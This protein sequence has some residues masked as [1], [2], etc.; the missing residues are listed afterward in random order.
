MT[1]GESLILSEKSLVQ[2]TARLVDEKYLFPDLVGG[3]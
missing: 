3:G 2:K 1:T